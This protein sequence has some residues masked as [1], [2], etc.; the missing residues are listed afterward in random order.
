VEFLTPGPRR[1]V[2]ALLDKGAATAG[3]LASELNLTA[4]AIRHHLD[5]LLA[6][7]YV[8][9]SDQPA[10]GPRVSPTRG[11][12][13]RYF[14]LT[15][16]GRQAF[17]QRYDDL[18]HAALNWALEVH[19]KDAI[20]Q[21]AEIQMKN[22]KEEWIKAIDEK[23][24]LRVK[25][26][27]LTEALTQ[28]GYAASVGETDGPVVQLSFHRCPI[29]NIAKEFPEIC[30]A[31]MCAIGETLGAHVTRIAT[32]AAGAEICTAIVAK[33]EDLQKHIKPI[34]MKEGAV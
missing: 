30:E 2:A 7:D 26:T 18:A 16:S 1:V 21:I 23:S 17:D 12:P 22:Q 4:A 27:Q 3:E 34:K 5:W 33:P 29:E 25:A 9:A 28:D 8:T 10:F 13:S 11:R 31:E 32:I 20:R 24:T 15:A 19:G 6:K 14:G